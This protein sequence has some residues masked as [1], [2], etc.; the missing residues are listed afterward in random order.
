MIIC[1]NCNHQNPDGAV[2]CEACY[3]P[4]PQK[5]ACPACGA[6]VQ[7]DA[8]FCGQCGADLR[9]ATPAVEPVIPTSNDLSIPDLLPPDPL[10]VPEPIPP[11]PVASEPQAAMA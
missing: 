6:A 9:G 7:S 1:P 10:V 2:Q 8:S 3:T 4:L 5:T 11:Q